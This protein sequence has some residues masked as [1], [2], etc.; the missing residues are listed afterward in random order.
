MEWNSESLARLAEIFSHKCS[1]IYGQAS[2]KDISIAYEKE[3]INYL[4]GLGL[5]MELI[6]KVEDIKGHCT[7]VAEG[8]RKVRIVNAWGDRY[9]DMTEEFAFKTLAL[10]FLP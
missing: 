4:L 5:K 7:F 3:W 2:S 6:V 8:I 1:I 9:I 10:G